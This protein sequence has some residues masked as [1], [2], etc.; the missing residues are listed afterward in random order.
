GICGSGL[1][2][3]AAVFLRNGLI[4]SSGMI[5]DPG[6]F[7][8][9]ADGIRLNQNDIVQFQL[10][11][12]AV[13]AGIC[14]LFDKSGASPQDLSRVCLA[15]AMGNYINVRNAVYTGIIPDAA[16]MTVPVGN[17][18]LT[19]AEMFLFEF[20]SPGPSSSAE[21]AE[22]IELSNE[23]RFQEYFMDKMVFRD[24]ERGKA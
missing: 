5:K 17:A 2:D 9:L 14:M 21:A 7:I 18:S 23:P 8:E 4:D 20:G 16:E 22:Y 19:G 3:A 13:R 6:G 11:K 12:G 24:A 15:G 10:A 1:I